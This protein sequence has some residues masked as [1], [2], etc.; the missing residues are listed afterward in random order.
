MRHLRSSEKVLSRK[1][2]YNESAEIS[3][4][5]PQKIIPKFSASGGGDYYNTNAFVAFIPDAKASGE[6][7][8]SFRFNHS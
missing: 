7:R 3:R 8:A 4:R 6:I 1:R 2:N 5:M